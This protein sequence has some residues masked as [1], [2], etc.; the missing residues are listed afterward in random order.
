MSQ[1]FKV[2]ASPRQ[3]FWLAWMLLSGKIKLKDRSDDR[4]LNRARKALGLLD[5]SEIFWHYNR[6]PGPL[7]MG[8]LVEDGETRNVFEVTTDQADFILTQVDKVERGPDVSLFAIGLLEQLEEKK[9]ATDAGECTPVDAAAELP[10]WKPRLNALVESP[11]LI[12]PML[13]ELAKNHLSFGAW[14]KACEEV[15]APPGEE[16]R[17]EPGAEATG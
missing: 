5:V 8:E 7:R 15:T 17:G 2:T 3:R 10:L 6:D 4:R 1:T 14:R 12:I 9:D 13:H 11:A 16:A